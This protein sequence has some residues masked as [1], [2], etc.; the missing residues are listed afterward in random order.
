MTVWIEIDELG[1]KASPKM[2]LI[3][4]RHIAVWDRDIDALEGDEV[5]ILLHHFETRT[6]RGFEKK[7][8]FI[9]DE[10]RDV[11]IVCEP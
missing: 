7:M 5:P 2:G 9:R 6:L 3:V 11:V 10:Y 4:L 1:R 8:D